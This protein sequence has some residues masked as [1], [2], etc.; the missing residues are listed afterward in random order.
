MFFIVELVDVSMEKCSS[1]LYGI[2]DS[3]FYTPVI[4]KFLLFLHHFSQRAVDVNLTTPDS[5][6]ISFFISFF[7]PLFLIT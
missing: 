5:S 1:N 7:F 3:L 4:M 2:K 6:D